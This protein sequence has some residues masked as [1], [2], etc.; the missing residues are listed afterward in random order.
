M[1]SCG[2]KDKRKRKGAEMEGRRDR[3]VWWTGIEVTRETEEQEGKIMEREGENHGR[4]REMQ[5]ASWGCESK[6][7]EEKGRDGT[8][9]REGEE[10]VPVRNRYDADSS[11]IYLV[12]R[13]PP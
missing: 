11:S 2:G 3:G 13:P 7:E 8:R 1:V 10:E 6:L 5:I 4:D 12:Q 9:D